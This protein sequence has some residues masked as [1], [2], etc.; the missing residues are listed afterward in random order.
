MQSAT[1]R[2]EARALRVRFRRYYVQE[3]ILPGIFLCYC[4]CWWWY[5]T[6]LFLFGLFG[7]WGVRKRI[8]GYS[9]STAGYSKYEYYGS[10]LLL[11]QE[12]L[13]TRARSV[14][15]YRQHSEGI[16]AHEADGGRLLFTFLHKSYI[17]VYYT[18]EYIIFLYFY[19][20]EHRTGISL[21]IG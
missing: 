16:A 11:A 18:Y 10:L 19:D 17:R 8:K 13:R 12:R 3:V 15:H 6:Y 20:T 4:W 9:S 21:I 14:S 5:H 1:I 7:D 2:L